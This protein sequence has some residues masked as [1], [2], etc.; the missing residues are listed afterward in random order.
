MTLPVD[1]PTVIRTIRR[2]YTDYEKCFHRP[3]RILV[4][5]TAM[6]LYGFRAISEDIDLYSADPAFQDI[7]SALEHELDLRIDVT[8]KQNLWGNLHIPDI[9]QD[10]H[11]VERLTLEGFSVDIAAI[12]PETLF[13]IKASTMREKDRKDL[14]AIW[15]SVSPEG[16]FGRADSLLQSLDIYEAEDVLMNLVSEVQLVSQRVPQA[17]WFSRA[18]FIR[19]HWGDLLKQ[20]FPAGAWDIPGGDDSPRS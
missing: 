13:V 2:L 12:S 15:K 4:A 17:T 19:E 20:A 14:F 16:I 8:H 7:A 10:A 9:E 18:P 1:R 11:I 5:I 6:A 3:P